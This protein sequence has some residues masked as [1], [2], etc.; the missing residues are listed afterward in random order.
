M[1]CKYS[2]IYKRRYTKRDIRDFSFSTTPHCRPARSRMIFV[3]RL[4]VKARV[5]A[6]P[7]FF[8]ALPDDISLARLPLSA[9]CFGGY[10]IRNRDN[11]SPRFINNVLNPSRRRKD[12]AWI[13][14]GKRASVSSERRR[15][16]PSGR[17]WAERWKFHRVEHVKP[18]QTGSPRGGWNRASFYGSPRSGSRDCIR[19]KKKIPAFS[20]LFPDWKLRE[21]GSSPMNHERHFIGNRIVYSRKSN[22]YSLRYLYY[23]KLFYHLQSCTWKDKGFNLLLSKKFRRDLDNSKIFVPLRVLHAYYST[24]PAR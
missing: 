16:R 4:H 5:F 6:L 8:P 7:E 3:P 11:I 15:I 22:Y 14:R 17:K 2:C 21:I 10:S 1:V 18:F 19:E 13:R 9:R 23:T 20:S 24:I 12:E